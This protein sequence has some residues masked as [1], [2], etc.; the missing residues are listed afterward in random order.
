MPYILV[1]QYYEGKRF[2]TLNGHFYSVLS[3][4]LS[5]FGWSLDHSCSKDKFVYFYWMKVNEI[6]ALVHEEYIEEL[7]S[8]TNVDYYANKL[9]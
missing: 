2:Q 7:T 1:S 5:D 4:Y 9:I 8:T 6:L 3:S